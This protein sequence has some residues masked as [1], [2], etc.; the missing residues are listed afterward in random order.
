[1]K[2]SGV[3]FN[4][5]DGV[6]S[7]ALQFAQNSPH[8]K[9]GNYRYLEQLYPVFCELHYVQTKNTA[10]ISYVEY[11]S[12][13]LPMPVDM[14]SLI[15]CLSLTIAF[16]HVTAYLYR[17]II[18]ISPV[19][20]RKIP[21]G[22]S[23]VT[24][25]ASGI[26]DYLKRNVFRDNVNIRREEKKIINAGYVSLDSSHNICGAVKSILTA[27]VDGGS[28]TK[29]CL[30][31]CFYLNDRDYIRVRNIVKDVA[32]NDLHRG[33]RVQ[34]IQTTNKGISRIITPTFTL[35]EQNQKKIEFFSLKMKK[36]PEQ[37]LNR[38]VHDFF[39]LLDKQQRLEKFIKR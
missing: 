27:S 1:M 31:E 9:K 23:K 17:S 4:Y 22:A 26:S 25:D 16:N 18:Y 13:H 38:V 35:S 33:A 6:I 14:P 30:K 12:Q 2:I 19:V 36:T 32:N 29:S 15:D 34:A 8:Y 21:A 24:T 7:K 37:T 10:L 3:F 11:F 39:I 28:L 5:N 20:P